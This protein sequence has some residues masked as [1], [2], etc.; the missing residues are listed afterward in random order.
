MEGGGLERRR[1]ELAPGEVL[2]DRPLV[3]FLYQ[4][5]THDLPAGR[6]AELV[7]MIRD[8]PPVVAVSF[9]NVHVAR[10]AVEVA[11]LLS[12]EILVTRQAT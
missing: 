10:Y 7:E 5:M 4:L 12:P 11:E 2:S 1:L 9:D 3:T 8:M 6:V